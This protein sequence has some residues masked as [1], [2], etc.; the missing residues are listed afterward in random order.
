MKTIVIGHRNP[1]TDSCAAATGYAALKV[2]LGYDNVVCAC[3]GRPGARTEYLYRMFK[4]ALP[5]IIEDVSPRVCDLMD[6]SPH[7]VYTG[8]TLLEAMDFLRCSQMSR[9]PVTSQDGRFVGMISL[10]DLADRMF[11]KARNTDFEGTGEGVVGKSIETTIKLAAHSLNARVASLAGDADSMR[12]F[13]VYVG[14]MSLSKLQADI[15]RENR[16]QM[17]IV[18]GDR[19]D[20]HRLLI[21]NGVALLIVTGNAP[22]DLDLLK[23]ARTNSTTVLQTP[24]D[25]AT[26]VRRLKFSSPVDGSLQPYIT[27]FAS[28]DKISDIVHQVRSKREDNFPVLD[29]DDTL[30]G[31]LSRF[32]LDEDSAVQLV[33]VDHNELNQAVKGA[34]EVPIVEIL[35]HHRINMAPTNQPI[36][37]IN[38]IVGSTSTL[39]TERYRMAGLEPAPEIAGILMGGLISDTLLLRSPTTTDRDRQALEY[40]KARSGADPEKLLQEYYNVGSMIATL[41][42]ADLLAA[43]RKIY[44]VGNATFAVSQ[45]EEAGF[46]NFLHSQGDIMKALAA[47]VE[48][49]ESA[50]AALFIT[51]VVRENSLLAVAGSPKYLHALPFHSREANLYDL[52]GIVSRKKQLLPALLKAFERI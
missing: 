13:N 45:V 34:S 43:D 46:E 33:L 39:V 27:R 2:M 44:H 21:E 37:V 52:K 23:L 48:E 5:E 38:D 51:D 32:A 49:T 16:E 6:T 42:T 47:Y 9:V 50:F 17:T 8:Q 31:T 24:F 41:P 14:A 3:A 35:D 30:L 4:V 12:R 10:F 40:L 11:Q 1:D 25:S 18:V 26:A 15:L 20:I 19:D 7:V 28:Q 22:V 36:V 29:K